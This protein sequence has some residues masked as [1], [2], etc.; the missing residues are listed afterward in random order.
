MFNYE[1]KLFLPS[2]AF[3]EISA[4]VIS[5]LRA[6][7]SANTSGAAGSIRFV[8]YLI[9]AG[10]G[11]MSQSAPA[12]PGANRPGVAVA[13]A[14]TRPCRCPDACG[15]EFSQ[16]PSILRDN[17]K[18]VSA[19]SRDAVRV[20]PVRRFPSTLPKCRWEILEEVCGSSLPGYPPIYCQRRV[21]CCTWPNGT[22]S[23]S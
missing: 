10:V 20:I 2:R 8:A 3:A 13:R 17:L 4:A 5:R 14:D 18:M 1:R 15:E 23:C 7:N 21:Y 6:G 22:K 19:A 9:L 12:E 11:A 16:P